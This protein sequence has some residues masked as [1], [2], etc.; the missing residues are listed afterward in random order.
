ENAVEKNE[1]KYQYYIHRGS[2]PA[3]ALRATSVLRGG[4]CNM[5]ALLAPPQGKVQARE[6]LI[7]SQNCRC[8]RSVAI[9]AF[10]YKTNSGLMEWT[11]TS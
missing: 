8:E 2:R 9:Q 3:P 7:Y 10:D 11:P 4:D 1:Q 6:M 5:G